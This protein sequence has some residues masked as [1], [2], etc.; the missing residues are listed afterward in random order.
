MS[1]GFDKQSYKVI[2][3]GVVLVVKWVYEGFQEG[4]FDFGIIRIED[5]NINWSLYLYLVN[6]VVEWVQYGD[7]S[8][9]KIMMLL[10]FQRVLDG[11]NI[12]VLIWFL[13][14]FIL[15][16]GNNIYV[17]GDNKGLVVYYFERSVRGDSVVVEGFVVGFLQVN[18]GDLL[19]NVLGVWCDDGFGQMCDF[20][21]SMCVDGKS[22]VCWVRGLV[23]EKLD[24]GV[25]SCEIIVQRQFDGVK[26]FYV[27]FFLVMLVGF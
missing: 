9:E 7:D 23:F 21:M 12:G 14:Y 13:V 25:V 16:Q 6:F 1:L 11:K 20:E 10:R 5:V 17:M 2:V 15:M 24:L 4:Y 3:D 8:V 22:Q 18:M 19:L 27:S 26:S